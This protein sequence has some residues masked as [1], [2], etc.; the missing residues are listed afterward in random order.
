MRIMLSTR[1]K[2]QIATAIS[3]TLRMARSLV[4]RSDHV[5]AVRGGLRWSLD[6]AE[7]IDLA[8]YLG[9]YQ[10]IGKFAAENILIPGTVAIDIGAN[11]GA[12]TLPLAASLGDAGHV[13]AIEP[14]DFA[15]EKLRANVGMNP[16]LS[17]HVTTIQALL[18][19]RDGE[20]G[21]EGVFSSWR[22]GGDAQAARHPEHGGVRMSIAGAVHHSLDSLLE[23]DARLPELAGRISFVKLDVDGHELDVLRGAQDL[24]R[25]RRPALLMEMAPYVQ[26]ERPG[27]TKV[28]LAEIEQLGYR[29][30]DP[31]SGDPLPGDEQGIKRLIPHGS[32]ID[33]LC[34]PK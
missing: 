10:R 16:R 22:L 17:R 14:T 29:L 13:I 20:A 4:G 25:S 15:Y 12:F 7:G 6:L 3:A 1:R 8:I 5:E 27:G 9:V 18:G 33:L 32:S 23:S 31:E 34:L 19:A 30:F 2:L 24:L 11:I 26:D 28:L 21:A